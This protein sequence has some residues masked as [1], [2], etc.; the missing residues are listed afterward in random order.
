MIEI[1]KLYKNYSSLQAVQ[2]LSLSVPKGQILGLLGPNGAGKSTT[3]RILTGFL[4]AT[5]G[6]VSIG[7]YSIKEQPLEAKRLIGYLPESAPLYLH[8]LV[9]D[10]LFF[11]ASTRGIEKSLRDQKIHSAAERCDILDVLHR[12]IGELSKG[13]R[14]RVGLA[15]AILDDPEV[16]I[17]DE[18][19]SGLDPNQI[20]GIRNIIKELGKEKTIIFSTHILSEAESTCDRLVIVNKGKIVADG[21]A[22]K[23]KKQLSAQAELSLRIEAESQP[24]LE[25]A[26]AHLGLTNCSKE[27]EEFLVTLN[28]DNK[29]LKSEVKKL[30]KSKGWFLLGMEEKTQGLEDIFHIL[31]KTEEK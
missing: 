26:F 15:M 22:D 2:E 30:I 12:P 1:K 23:L 28:S 27:G 18:P 9:Y 3:L 17:L 31:T 7:G 6:E 11:I 13:Y 20:I 19:T 8:M 21:D 14:Q 5:A 16:L 10:Y 25:S 4:E 24:E 29:D